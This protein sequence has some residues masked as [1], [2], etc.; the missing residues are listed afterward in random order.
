MNKLF[1]FDVDG[2]IANSGQKITHEMSVILNKIKEN[3]YEIGIVGGGKLDKILDQMDNKIYF[4]HYF[5]ECGSVYYKNSSLESNDLIEVYKKNI[6]NHPLYKDKNTLIK[7][8]IKFLSNVDYVI[9]GNFID[10]RNGIIY[11]S[12]IG[13]TA[14]QDEREYFMNLDKKFNYR[15]QLIE[16]L[17]YIT[18]NLGIY[19]KIDIVEGGSVGIAIYPSEY[20]KIQ[21]LDIFSEKEY[22]TIYYFGDK[23]EPNGN[24][25]KILNNTRV[26]GIPVNNYQDTINELINLLNL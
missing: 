10:L 13:L 5:T 3:G 23:Y 8:C 26:I 1:L 4:Q 6:R 14:T 11:V 24:D 25:Y 20:D 19:N 18:S 15:Q 12:L 22:D 2:T 7:H 21:V 9:T 17:K 16:S